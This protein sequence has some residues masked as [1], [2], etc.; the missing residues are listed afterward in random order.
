MLGEEVHGQKVLSGEYDFRGVCARTLEYANQ[1][2]TD[3]VP[4]KPQ[5]TVQHGPGIYV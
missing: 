2:P 3:L 4:D 5:V 1:P